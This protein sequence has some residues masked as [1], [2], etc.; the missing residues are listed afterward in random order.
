MAACRAKENIH[1]LSLELFWE[2]IL[3]GAASLSLRFRALALWHERDKSA[4]I[5]SIISRER[6]FNNKFAL[7]I[8]FKFIDLFG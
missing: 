4:T 6:A 5:G 1:T 2:G 8:I 7:D 3:V